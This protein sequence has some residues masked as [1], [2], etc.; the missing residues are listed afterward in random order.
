LSR[1]HLSAAVIQAQLFSPA[2][3]VDAGFLD[4][5]TETDEVLETT[6]KQARKLGELP[7][8]AYGANKRAIREPCLAKIRESLGV[9]E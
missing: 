6:L 2:E 8:Q 1:R 9:S 5:L 7:A 4:Q 3:A